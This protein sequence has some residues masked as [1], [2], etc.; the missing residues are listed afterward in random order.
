MEIKNITTIKLHKD[1]ALAKKLI[2]KSINKNYVY[3]IELDSAKEVL[4]EVDLQ[5]INIAPYD[6]SIWSVNKGHWDIYRDCKEGIEIDIEGGSLVA[7]SPLLDVREKAVVAIDFGTKSTIAGIIDEEGERRLLRIGRQSDSIRADD[8][9]NPT[10]INFANI[11]GFMRDYTSS[12]TRPLTSWNDVNISHDAQEQQKEAG[13]ENFEQF[14]SNLKQWAGYGKTYRIKSSDI[15]ITLKEFLNINTDSMDTSMADLNP[16]ELYAYYIGRFINNMTNGI[17]LD[18]LLSYPDKFEPE[19]REQIRISFEKGLYKAIPYEVHKSDKFG[20]RFRVRQI[21][22][23]P[24]A[25]A[26]SALREYGFMSR[27]LL[28]RGDVHYGVFDFGGGTTDFDFGVLSLSETKGYKFDL[29]HFGGGGDRELGGENLLD[30]LAFEAFR[31][32]LDSMKAA[33]CKFAAPIFKVDMNDELR[34]SIDDSPSAIKNTLEMK[35]YLRDIIENVR[36][37]RDGEINLSVKG[38]LSL[39]DVDE[40]MQS[41]DL[42]IDVESLINIL[43]SKIKVGVEKFFEELLHVTK[44]LSGIE[45]LNIFLGGNASKSPLVKEAFDN[46]IKSLQKENDK[47]KFELFAPLGSEESREQLIALKREDR[48][49]DNDLSRKVTCKTGVVFGLLD[50]RD[51]SREINIISEVGLESSA[52]FE[53][54]LSDELDDDI[55]IPKLKKEDLNNREYLEFLDYANLETFEVYYTADAR[56]GFE[57]KKSEGVIRR[58]PIILEQ[59]YSENDK[60]YIKAIGA[61]R[62]QVAVFD[63]SGSLLYESEEIILN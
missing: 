42:S 34:L 50:S 29:K 62:I 57:L 61:D 52:K 7:R 44:K 15:I 58:V 53:Y 22:T 4:Q 56:G 20:K 49:N 19:V 6:K 18:Y 31:L 40:K 2:A 43:E 48:I 10:I 14:F 13:L 59:E 11:I 9:E 45:K 24:A 37:A 55:F 32:N 41:L 23:E 25:Y 60:I 39:C 12:K 51:S 17:Y 5:C 21:A 35:N 63:E 28:E 8:Y 38:K 33:K 27:K 1:E 36:A 26:I 47:L 3:S 30:L 46:K 16:I 54:H